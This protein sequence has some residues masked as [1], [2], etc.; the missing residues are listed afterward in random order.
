M[1]LSDYKGEEALDVLADMLEP[2]SK[3]VN[4]DKVKDLIGK[5]KL[6]LVAYVIRNHKEDVLKLMAA[7]ERK[8]V[9]TFKNTVTVFT[10][11]MKLL[12]I[13]NDPDVQLLFTYQGQKG[14][15]T[16]SGSVSETAD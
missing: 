6:E 11:P 14:D 2:T 3:I 10:L 5:S 16:S 15:A 13:I 8:D 7:L 1:R 12:D 9:E 4:D